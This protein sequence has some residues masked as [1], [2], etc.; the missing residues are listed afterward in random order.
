MT[1]AEQYISD[2]LSGAQL[3]GRY[4]RLAVQRHVGMLE[5]AEANGWYF[6]REDAEHYT[7][8]FRLCFNSI[9]CG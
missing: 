2:V 6:D 5:T 1:L 7:G 4:V 3:A 9:W 8:L